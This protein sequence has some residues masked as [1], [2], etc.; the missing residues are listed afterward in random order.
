MSDL[1][2]RRICR[3]ENNFRF[4]KASALSVVG[5]EHSVRQWEEKWL[6]DSRANVEAPAFMGLNPASPL[7]T[8]GPYT[9]YSLLL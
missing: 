6:P 1:K 4:N 8:I 2:H 5:F 7:L 3:V 9:C